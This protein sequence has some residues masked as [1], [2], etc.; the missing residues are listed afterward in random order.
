MRVVLI[1]AQSLDGFITRHDEPGVA[2]ASEA[3]QR[4]FRQSLSEF[5]CQVMASGTYDTVRDFLLAKHEDDCLR[6]V[7]SRRMDNYRKD[8]LTGALEFTSNSPEEIIQNL[9]K[10]GRK[11]CALLGGATAHDTFLR[12]GRVDEIWVTLEPR[13]FGNGTPIVRDQQ[14]QQLE[15]IDY[16]RLPNS[17][18]LV[19]RYRVKK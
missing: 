12:G 19:V 14:D 8:E 11:S 17:D 1:V 18:S 10:A 5:D 9:E 2:W 4:W 15:I 3:D 13:L 16:Q 7:M 6:I